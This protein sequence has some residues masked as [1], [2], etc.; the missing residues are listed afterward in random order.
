MN[1]VNNKKNWPELKAYYEQH[2]YVVIDTGFDDET[3]ESLASDLKTW[4]DTDQFPSEDYASRN[5]NRIQDA[6]RFD[7][8]VKEIAVNKPIMGFLKYL[9]GQTPY[10][11]QTLN[12]K[13]GTEQPAHSDTIHFNSEPFGMMCGVWLALEDIGED[14]GPLMFYPGSQHYPEMNYAE[15]G[16]EPGGSDFREYS[17]KLKSFIESEKLEPTYGI[18]KKGQAIIWAA[19][20]LHGG[21]RRSS[22]KTRLSQ[23]SHYY[24]ANCKYWRP[25][26]SHE[27]R[28]YFDPHW[29]PYP[30]NPQWKSRAKREGQL[31]VERAKRKLRRVIKGN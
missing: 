21:S 14:Q 29:I 31:L 2:G 18:L 4:F 6:W 1:A 22:D 13:N 24:F 10:P 30:G 15:L 19:N 23:V 26:M 16:I 20:L 25:S 7:P 5:K 12:F 17:T 3:I 27:Q 11:F 9:Y 8:R 28:H